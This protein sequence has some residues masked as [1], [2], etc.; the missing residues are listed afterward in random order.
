[1]DVAAIS[2]YMT[3][4][5]CTMSDMLDISPTSLIQAVSCDQA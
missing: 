5:R 4:R 3:T 2:M 1:M